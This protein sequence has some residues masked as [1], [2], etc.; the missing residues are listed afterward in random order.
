MKIHFFWN[1]LRRES[2]NTLLTPTHDH[3]LNKNTRFLSCLAQF[4]KLWICVFFNL[5]KSKKSF[6]SVSQFRFQKG[7][8][9]SMHKSLKIGKNA[10][11]CS[12]WATTG[13]RNWTFKDP[14]CLRG[15]L[16]S[17]PLSLQIVD[18]NRRTFFS[19]LLKNTK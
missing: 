12:K 6:C 19:F 11:F 7:G 9:P 10:H 3:F 13:T 16:F 15:I 2:E 4:G 1:F 5:K 14:R 18:I 8:S 17:W